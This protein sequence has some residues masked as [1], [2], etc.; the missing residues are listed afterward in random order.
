[1]DPDFQRG[2]VWTP[3][4]QVAYVEYVLRGG[5][6]G[7]TIYL[8]CPGWPISTE[9]YVLVDG[10]QRLTAVMG[11]LRDEIKAFNYKHSEF[12]GKIRLSGPRFRWVVNNL[13]TRAAVLQWYLEM[14]TGGTV[15]SAAEINK[16]RQML[17]EETA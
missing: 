9:D 15:H 8:N 17:A 4:Q 2:H 7:N 14:N 5:T 13:P 3:E 11:F 12:T 1:M 6:S 16:V 10:K